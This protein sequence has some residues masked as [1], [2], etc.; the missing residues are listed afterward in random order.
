MKDR[1][2]RHRYPAEIIKYSVMLYYRFSLSFRDIVEILAYRGIDVSHEAIRYWVN[3]FGPIFTQ[4]ILKKRSWKPGDKWHFDEVRIVMNGEVYW[5]WRAIDQDN[6]ELDIL[7][8]RRRNTKAA[9]RFFKKILKKYGFVPRVIITDKLRSYKSARKTILKSTEHR[10]HK[11]L[12]NRIENSHQSTRIQE[13]QMRKFKSP[14]GAQRFLSICGQFLNLLK[15]PRVKFQSSI[16]RDK[17]KEAFACFNL[18]S[19]T[20]LYNA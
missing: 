1:Y 16:Y 4:N 19:A 20:N 9:K 13:R 5:L 10:S 7:L 17:L 3:K 11:R 6:N 8:Q 18:A 12:N 15:I 2:K 14:G